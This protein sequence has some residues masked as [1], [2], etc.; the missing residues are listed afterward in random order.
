MLNKLLLSLTL[1]LTVLQA[2]IIDTNRIT[3]VNK[4]RTSDT[5]II[6]DVD[7][8]TLEPKQTLGSDQW[9]YYIYEDYKAKCND[10]EEAL[11]K[12]LSQWIA[13]QNLT[14]VKLVEKQIR[15]MIEAQQSG[16]IHLMGLTTRDCSLAMCTQKQLKS[17]DIDFS[18]TAPTER[19]VIFD[20]GDVILFR[21]GVLYTSGTHKGEAFFQFLDQIGYTPKNI[22]FINDKRSNLAQLEE[23]CKKKNI[24]FTGLRYGYLDDKVAA[25]DREV[26]NMQHKFFGKLMT[27]QEARHLLMTLSSNNH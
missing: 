1:S 27:D 20:K 16:G 19:D 10:E 24:A 21:K 22:L 23:T 15:P 26:A 7:N 5:L 11:S 4:Y 6:Y 9:F 18:K 8:T 25:F 2:E 17:V 13:I 3:D 14:E 12:A